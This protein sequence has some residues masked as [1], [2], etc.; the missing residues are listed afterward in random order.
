MLGHIRRE[1][2][3]LLRGDLQSAHKPPQVL[4]PDGCLVAHLVNAHER[5]GWSAAKP[6][7]YPDDQEED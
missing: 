1:P 5:D 4:L 3:T 7:S 2:Y 6:A